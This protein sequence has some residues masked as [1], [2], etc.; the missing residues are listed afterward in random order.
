VSDRPTT[1]IVIPAYNASRYVAVAVRSVLDQTDRDL[2]LLV[3]DDGSEDD[4]ADVAERAIAGDPRGRVIRGDHRGVSGGLRE[5]FAMARGEFVG[6]VDAD[7][8]LH[9][10]AVRACRGRLNTHPRAGFV[11]TRHREI[12]EHGRIM[13]AGRR[14]RIPFDMN[15][16]LI[17]FMTFHFRL[18]RKS[19]Y[20]AAGGW[21]P[22]FDKA[23]DYDMCLRLAEVAPVC[24]LPKTLYDYR[25]HRTSISQTR[26]FEQALASLR[27]VNE[28]LRRRGQA[29]EF[30][31]V[32]TPQ[33]RFR[34]RRRQG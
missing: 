17:D 26:R 8:R 14:D 30:E 10:S 13:R 25:V 6:Q 2:E 23:S 9:L 16:M 31:V 7:D 33:N 27:A 32:L 4:T 28:A 5:A 21:D 19:A 11:Y 29:D 22:V 15:R 20:E 24:H 3:R 12:D 34:L 18:I 1:T